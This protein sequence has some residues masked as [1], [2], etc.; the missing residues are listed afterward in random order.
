MNMA[1]LAAQWVHSLFPRGEFLSQVTSDKAAKTLV[2]M[3]LN[4]LESRRLRTPSDKSGDRNFVL[5]YDAS[6]ARSFHQSFPHGAR[7]VLAMF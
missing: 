3:R 4:N 2:K 5:S 7:S 1:G 6:C